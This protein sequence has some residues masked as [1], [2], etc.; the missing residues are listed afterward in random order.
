MINNIINNGFKSGY[1]NKRKN[2]KDIM[3][4]RKKIG[5]GVYVT[6]NINIAKKF[7]GKMNIGGKM[8]L[9]L[10]LVKVKQNAIRMCNCPNA[11]D[12]WVLRDSSQEIRP[13]SVL[14]AEP[15]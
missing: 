13:I 1:N 9:T 2:C 10:F 12:F 7:A 15:H 3:H 6:P 14:L 5:N 4:P 8:F 11:S